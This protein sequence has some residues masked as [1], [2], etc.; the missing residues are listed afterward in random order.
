MSRTL[1]LVALCL[2]AIVALRYYAH[3]P[4][5]EEKPTYWV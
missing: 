2:A 1:L 4:S 5:T 3:A